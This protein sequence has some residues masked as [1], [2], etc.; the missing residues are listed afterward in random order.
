VTAPERYRRG[1]GEMA[2]K[3]QIIFNYFT[4]DPTHIVM[5]CHYV[6]IPA[7]NVQKKCAIR[8]TE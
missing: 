8:Y 4:G 2:F 7:L 6:Y 1:K 3:P 5:E